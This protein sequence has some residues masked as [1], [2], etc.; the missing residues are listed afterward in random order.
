K[1][2]FLPRPRYFAVAELQHRTAIILDEFVGDV[3][4]RRVGRHAHLGSHSITVV[5]NAML[6][7]MIKVEF[8]EPAA[9]DDF[10]AAMPAGVENAAHLHGK[11]RLITAVDA[12]A[13]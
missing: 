3:G 11:F 12:L 8:I 9:A 1:H 2:L 10:N 6:G 5:R 7:K 4:Q 13:D